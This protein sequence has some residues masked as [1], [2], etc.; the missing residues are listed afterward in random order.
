MMVKQCN[1]NDSKAVKEPRAAYLITMATVIH[2]YAQKHAHR[3][4]HI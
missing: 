3:D 2:T 4:T 1:L